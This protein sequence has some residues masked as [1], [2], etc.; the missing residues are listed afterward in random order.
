MLKPVENRRY[1]FVLVV[2]SFLFFVAPFPREYPSLLLVFIFGLLGVFGTVIHTI[3]KARLPRLLAICTAAVALATGVMAFPDMR[4]EEPVI[5]YL[6]ACCVAYAAFILIAIVSI[7][8]D[9]LFRESVTL[10]CIWGSISVYMFLGMFF[11]FLFGFLV[12]LA[13]EAFDHTT[14]AGSPG[15]LRL[16]DLLYF[17]YS[18]L[19]TT[20]YGDIA[21]S[22]PF[23]R[24]LANFESIVGTLDIAVMISRLVSL[25]VAEKDMAKP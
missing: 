10:D 1:W 20:G 8:A 23:A 13:P 9:V 5:S 19:T 25:H 7:G 2:Q 11:A 16:N 22:H 3:W 17:S 14:R 18:T 6:M 15:R 24:T 4:F 12:F 21:P